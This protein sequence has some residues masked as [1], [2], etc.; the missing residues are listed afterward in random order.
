M[1]T[2]MDSDGSVKAVR[3][4]GGF[5]NIQNS[6]LP[7]MTYRRHGVG[8]I[9]TIRTSLIPSCLSPISLHF[10]PVQHRSLLPPSVQSVSSLP[11]GFVIQHFIIQPPIIGGV[12]VCALAR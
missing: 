5:D 1:K 12:P 9:E 2:G 3:E 10:T 6:P 8:F 11:L 4:A 7:Q